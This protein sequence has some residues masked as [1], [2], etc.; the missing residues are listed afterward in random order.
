MFMLNRDFIQWVGLAFVIATPFA[1]YLMHSWLEGFAY[2]TKMSWWIFAL[3]G[4][5]TLLVTLISVSLHSWKAARQ[6]PVEALK[7]E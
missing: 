7:Y 2:K 6:N 5:I 3:A 1:L 4:V